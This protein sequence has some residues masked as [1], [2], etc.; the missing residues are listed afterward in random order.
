M[1]LGIAANG[2]GSA[3]TPLVGDELGPEIAKHAFGVVARG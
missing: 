2:D 1:K 3:L